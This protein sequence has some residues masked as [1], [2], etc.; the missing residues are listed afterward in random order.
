[1]NWKASLKIGCQSSSSGTLIGC[2]KNSNVWPSSSSVACFQRS[3]SPVER[4][5]K[6]CQVIRSGPMSIVPKASI[7]TG[8]IN[9][10]S[11]RSSRLAA[12]RGSSP[13][14]IVPF[15]NWHPAVGCRKARTSRPCSVALVTTG[16]A[17]WTLII[18]NEL[19]VGRVRCQC[20]LRAECGPGIL[21]LGRKKPSA[22]PVFATRPDGRTSCCEQRQ[23]RGVKPHL[24]QNTRTSTQQTQRP[25]QSLAPAAFVTR[26]S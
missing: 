22:Q 18:T 4:Q 5:L 13:S 26:L 12:S 11:S 25:G 16:Q 2:Q 1:M 19:N 10:L 3:G 8:H 24:S 20:P 7:S 9:P 23:P 17:F 6:K 15:T 14:P 21:F